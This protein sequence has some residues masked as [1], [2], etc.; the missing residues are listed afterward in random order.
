MSLLICAVLMLSGLF[1]MGK[2]SD[3]A[4]GLTWAIALYLGLS[5]FY[6]ISG[7]LAVNTRVPKSSPI[8]ILFAALVFR[9]AAWFIPPTLSDDLFRYRFE[10]QIQA[11]GLNP[12]LVRPVS[13]DPESRI[14]AKDFKAGYGPLV[15]RIEAWNWHLAARFSSDPV[16]QTRMF[17]IP[18]M[19]FDL[20]CLAMLWLMSRDRFIYYAWCPLTFIEFW[21]N[22][23]N[24]SI[25]LF[26]LLLAIWAARRPAAYL[27]LGFGIAAKWWPAALLL[28]FTGR[29][30]KRLVHWP[31][32]AIP[33][34]AF[35]WAY[36]ANVQENARFMTGF[37]GGWRNN[38]S[39][40]GLI[41]ILIPNPDFAKYAAFTLFGLAAL[42]IALRDWPVERR[43]MYTLAAL[44]VVSANVH[45]WYLTW[46]AVLLPLVPSRA[47]LCWVATAP[48]FHAAI[49]NY[50]A[51]G[52]WTTH[53][54]WRWAVYVPVFGLFA[55]EVWLSFRASAGQTPPHS[56]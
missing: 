7:Q 44:L 11:Q 30:W 31:F 18:A 19:L 54:A 42:A 38:D 21:S 52:V 43:V 53:T 51:T 46:L 29:N 4:T 13:V 47:V 33:V 20:A 5:L 24:D 40:F 16:T 49:I 55:W 36:W 39:L 28:A 50:H 9:G 37:V 48:L 1:A 14:P 23:H 45:V 34:A 26:F 32:A 56:T 27:W 15:E 2:L 25:V 22:G 41:S 8:F 35:G 17:R 10:G 6:L 12:D 3:S